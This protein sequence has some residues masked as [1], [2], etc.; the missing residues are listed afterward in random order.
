MAINCTSTTYHSFGP[1]GVL[2]WEERKKRVR[3]GVCRG[4]RGVEKKETNTRI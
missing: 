2:Q 4:E 3:M 1:W